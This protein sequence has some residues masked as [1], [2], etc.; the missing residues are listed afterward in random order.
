MMHL[1]NKILHM[2]RLHNCFELVTV[3]KLS[4][5]DLVL[6]SPTKAAPSF[7]LHRTNAVD[8]ADVVDVIDVVDVADVVYI[9]RVPYFHY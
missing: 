6:N 8:V 3:T 9:D 4:S 1:N 7:L 2:C 5:F